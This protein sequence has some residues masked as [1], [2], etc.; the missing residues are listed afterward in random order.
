MIAA[1]RSQ[2]FNILKRISC[3]YLILYVSHGLY[4]DTKEWVLV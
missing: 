2:P 4:L 3:R 1:G